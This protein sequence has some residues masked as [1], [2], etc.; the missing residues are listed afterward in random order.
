MVL[1]EDIDSASGVG[2]VAQGFDKTDAD[3]GVDDVAAPLW[4]AQLRVFL[5]DDGRGDHD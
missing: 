1:D 3:V 4:G 5:I 2:F